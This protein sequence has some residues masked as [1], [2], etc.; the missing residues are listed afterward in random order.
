[1]VPPC[2]HPLVQAH[3]LGGLLFGLMAGL[4]ALVVAGAMLFAGAL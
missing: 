2:L 3:L 4:L 1:M